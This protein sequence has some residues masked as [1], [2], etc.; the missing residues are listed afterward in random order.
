MIISNSREVPLL[1]RSDPEHL[2][3]AD[4]YRARK[5]VERSKRILENTSA[6]DLIIK[7]VKMMSNDNER[8]SRDSREN[9]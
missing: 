7:M 9:L 6:Y 4:I 1:K 8:N 5:N 3:E 2:S